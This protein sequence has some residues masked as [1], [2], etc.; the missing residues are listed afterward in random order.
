MGLGGASCQ[1]SGALGQAQPLLGVALANGRVGQGTFHVGCTMLLENRFN[2]W[3]RGRTQ[4]WPPF[5]Q[6]LDGHISAHPEQLQTMTTDLVAR[7]EELVGAAAMDLDSP[8]EAGDDDE[9]DDDEE[10]DDDDDEE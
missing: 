2:P 1:V 7:L 5:P 4:P 6:M 3:S 8:L 9:D 10:Y